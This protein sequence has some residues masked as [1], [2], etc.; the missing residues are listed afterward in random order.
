MAAPPDLIG[1]IDSLDPAFWSGVAYRHTARTVPPLSAA[2]AKAF[3]G[4]WNPRDLFGAVYLAVPVEAAV[5]EF[6]RM[7]EGQARGAAS[8]LP[9]DLHTVRVQ[10]IQVLDLTNPTT[11]ASLG[12]TYE[13]LTMEGRSLCQ[14]I[15]QAAHFL[16][17]QGIIA[18]SAT[19]TGDV[20]AVFDDRISLMEL[21]VIETN[22]LSSMLLPE[23][24]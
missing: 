1:S 3:G 24:F 4:R 7:A 14:E 13:E 15:A 2:G 22:E 9:R 19:G 6:R 8:F 17:Y 20:I 18:P 23:E 11:V 21:E 5:E 10:P 12:L 16:G